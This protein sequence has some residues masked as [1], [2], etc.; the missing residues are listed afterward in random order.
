ML[1]CV[2]VRAAQDK[3]WL[4]T[5]TLPMVVSSLCTTGTDQKVHARKVTMRLS[6]FQAA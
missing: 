5:E 2:G 6:T 1:T 3:V 4:D